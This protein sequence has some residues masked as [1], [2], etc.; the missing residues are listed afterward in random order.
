M[1]AKTNAEY[2]AAYRAKM[3]AQGLWEVKGIYLP[4]PLH[5]K[6]KDM[7]RKLDKRTKGAI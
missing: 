5:A 4:K 1:T 7:A 3:H 2:Q 6:L